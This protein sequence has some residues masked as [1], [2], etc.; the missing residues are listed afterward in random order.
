MNIKKNKLLVFQ[1]L[2]LHEKKKKKKNCYLT[3]IKKFLNVVSR[4]KRPFLIRTIWNTLQKNSDLFQQ[5][6]KTE[7]YINLN[8]KQTKEDI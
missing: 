6:W 4:A 3:L 8:I 5:I 7:K 1:F 2:I